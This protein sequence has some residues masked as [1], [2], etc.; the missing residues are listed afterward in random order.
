MICSALQ[1][2]NEHALRTGA[3]VWHAGDLGFH[4]WHSI[5]HHEISFLSNILEL[6]VVVG[7][8]RTLPAVTQPLHN[9]LQ[10][11]ELAASK[12][13]KLNT[14]MYTNFS[15]YDSWQDN[16]TFLDLDGCWD[17]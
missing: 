14:H 5:C 10:K 2:R 17:R 8:S 6:V 1:A 7:S 13:T 9:T 16:K 12:K 15:R 3:H 11:T 4:H